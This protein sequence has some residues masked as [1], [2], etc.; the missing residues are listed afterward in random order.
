[1]FR[2]EDPQ[3]IDLQIVVNHVLKMDDQ[4]FAGNDFGVQG[5]VK[6]VF[7]DMLGGFD[8]TPLP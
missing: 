3:G 6:E 8:E 4:Q 2:L 5:G 1:M 7:G